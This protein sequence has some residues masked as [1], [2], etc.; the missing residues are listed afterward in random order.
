MW[1][2]FQ[3]GE[4]D[5]SQAPPDQVR[6]RSPPAARSTTATWTARLVAGRGP[7]LRRHE[8]DRPHARGQTS[9]CARPSASRRTRRRWSTTS[10]RAWPRRPAA[11]C[12]PASRATRPPRTPTPTTWPPPRPRS[13]RWAPS[14]RSTTGT[15]STRTTGCIAEALVAGWGQAGLTV[16]ASEYEWGTYLDKLSRGNHGSGSQLFRVAWIADYPAMDAFLYPLFQSDQSRDRQL[17]LLLEQ[18]RG[19]P[20]AEGARHDGRAAAAEPVRAG[21]EAHP[22]RH[23][24]GA[25]RTSTATSASSPARRARVPG[26]PH[27]THGHACAVAGVGGGVCSCD[28]I[29][30]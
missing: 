21:G 27:G 25:A 18:G 5:C 13:P 14:P 6:G 17:H 3:G 22:R 30:E 11:T 20:A 23:A 7:L 29:V 12:R 24:G 1:A 9:S 10:A 26:R 16:E 19:R 4:L 28:C 8:H 15:T 2:A